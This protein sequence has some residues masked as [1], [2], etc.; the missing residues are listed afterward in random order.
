M[1]KEIQGTAEWLK[2]RAEGVG[3]SESPIIM[4]KSRFKTKL[5]LYHQKVN[6]SAP[7]ENP[8]PNFIFEKGHRLEEI[9]R[10]VLELETFQSW[11]P[12]ILEH[13]QMPRIRCS[14]DGMNEAEDAIWE[15]KFMGKDK[16]EALVNYSQVPA[17]YYDQLMHQVLVTDAKEIWFT[18]IIDHSVN[19]RLEKGQTQQHTIVIPVTEEHRTYIKETLVPAIINFINCVDSKVPPTLSVDDFFECKDKELGKLLTKYKNV[20][21]KL[22]DA[23]KDESAL[24][25]QIFAITSKIHNKVKFKDYKISETM[26][27]GKEVPDYDRY[28]ADNGIDLVGL[29][30]MKMSKGRSTRK[31]SI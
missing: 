16:Y 30:Y 27:K 15:C 22:D 21:I 10:K 5:E 24:K 17:E 1:S 23:K 29:G 19:K 4:G 9:A 31:I 13:E 20:K 8:T 11:A 12:K 25:D 18:G 14:L 6:P 26:S 28:L 2:W 7:E 3:A